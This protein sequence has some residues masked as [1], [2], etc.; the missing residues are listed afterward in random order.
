MS[1]PQYPVVAPQCG[2]PNC[3]LEICNH[4][5]KKKP[6]FMTITPV[7][8]DKEVV[9]DP[10][11]LMKQDGFILEKWHESDNESN[12]QHYCSSIQWK[13][14]MGISEIRGGYCLD[15]HE[16]IPHEIVGAWTMHNWNSLQTWDA[17][18]K[19]Y[20]NCEPEATSGERIRVFR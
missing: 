17:N 12:I 7:H 11:V 18:E 4:Q 2:D 5:P 14:V 9:G 16:D 15:C 13:K 3:D 20:G 1:S 19:K 10:V 6:W 8:D